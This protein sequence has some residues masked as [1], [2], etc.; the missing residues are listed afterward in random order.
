MK[1]APFLLPAALLFWAWNSGLWWLAL[2]MALL[3]ELPRYTDWHWELKLQERRR[4]ADLCTLMILGAAIYLYLTQPR[5]GRAV[6]VLIQWSPALLFPLIAVQVYGG[7]QGVE[8]SV[9]FLSLRRH[10]EADKGQLDLRPAYLITCLLATAMTSPDNPRYLPGL[11]LLTAW[12]LWPLRARGRPAWVWGGVMLLVWGLAQG[13]SLGMRQAQYQMEDLMVE[14]ITQW[15]SRS[16][17]PY[18]VSTAIGDVGRLK[19]SERIMLRAQIP[20]PLWQSLLL[21]SASYTRY[22]DGTW[23][24]GH[25]PFDPLTQETAGWSLGE[26]VEGQQQMRLI[27]E[28]S[29]GRG[30]LPLPPG[31]IRAK[32]LEGA[33]LSRNAY[34]AVK[35]LEGP[36]SARLSIAY[37]GEGFSA[38]PDE[39][40]LRVPITERE[41]MSRWLSEQGLHDTQPQQLLSRMDALFENTFRYSLRLDRGP[42]GRGALEHFLFE[43]RAGHCEFFATASVLLLR[44]AGVP[45]RYVRGWSLNEYSELEQAYVARARHAHAWVEAW[46]DGAWQAFDPTPSQW[47]SLEAEDSPWWSPMYSYWQRWMYLLTDAAEEEGEAPTELLWL[48]LPLGGFLVW[49]ILRRGRVTGRKGELKEKTP[50]P[51]TLFSPVEE[52]LAR[53]GYSRAPHETLLEW[54]R[55]L[56]QE[57]VE[58]IHGLSTLVELYYRKCFDPLGSIPEVETE[59]ERRA[60]EWLRRHSR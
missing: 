39:V 58:E 28:L 30:V 59:L 50:K 46:I 36:E 7:R 17:D 19:M 15:M 47:E 16:G 40:D 51:R 38:P 26:T 55:R 54:E 60:E 5:L 10:P 41:V 35:I 24:A 22:F 53:L 29:D 34:G 9:L 20:L 18:Q 4:V 49:R 43:R 14:W 31:P 2:P 48:L 42:S 56:R 3:I 37:G 8:P 23:L 44:Q 27:F 13:L 21:R 12:A 11:A 32:G 57:G 25:T 6:I 33:S 1:V 52:H 45:A